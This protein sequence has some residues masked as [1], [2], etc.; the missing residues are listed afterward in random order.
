VVPSTCSFTVVD[1]LRQAWCFDPSTTLKL[2]CNLR[3]VRGTGKSDKESFYTSALWL[4]KN[5]PRTL[6]RNVKVMVEFRCFK[7]LVEILYRL[8]EGESV[9]EDARNEKYLYSSSSDE[10]EDAAVAKPGAADEVEVAE[11]R[12]PREVRV[13]QNKAKVDAVKAKARELRKEKELNKAKR[14]LE[15]YSNDPA[16]R[17]LHNCVADDMQLYKA[18]EFGKNGLAS[19]W[20]PSIDSSYDKC[21]LICESIARRVFPRDSY[22]EYEGTEEARYVYLV[23]DRLRKQVLELPE[24]Y[25]SANQWGAFRF[26]SRKFK[27]QWERM[28]N[29]MSKN[30]KL[31]NCIAVCDVSGSMSGTPMEVCVAIGLLISELSEEPWKGKVITFSAEPQLHLIKGNSLLEK[32]QF[33]RKIDWGGNTNFQVVFDRILQVAVHGNLREDHMIKKVIVFSDMEFD[34]ATG[35][36]YLH[37]DDPYSNNTDPVDS[38]CHSSDVESDEY[39]Y[40][41][42]DDDVYS[43]SSMLTELKQ[44]KSTSRKGSKQRWY[45]DSD[46]QSVDHCLDKIVDQ[47]KTP[48]QQAWDSD[49]EVI[50]RKFREKGFNEVPEI[51]FWNLRDSKAIPVN[52]QQTGV[53][54]VSGFSKNMAKLFL[55]GGEFTKKERKNPA[56]VMEQAISGEL[57]QKL[58]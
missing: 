15:R 6:A 34:Q 38:D 19:K 5:H 31:N 13:A 26:G 36:A 57:Y 20:C 54:L 37:M 47:P 28:V 29:D 42:S 35:L 30:G 24:V 40:G 7:D 58:I 3:G 8:M 25:M 55:E 45:A 44:R 50:V 41:D 11:Q 10:E 16:Y 32:T 22:P 39:L 17:F 46:G 49:Y 53:A 23:R 51:V 9:R 12:L 1:Y 2:I 14:A 21:T 43:S 48:K 33:V 56:D 18:G 27:M 4:H 52:A